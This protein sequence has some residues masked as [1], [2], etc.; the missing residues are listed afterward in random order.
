MRRFFSLSLATIF[1]VSL[2]GPASA[3]IFPDVPESY[4]Y[5][6]AI[7]G[8]VNAGVITGN[9]DG[10]FTPNRAVNRAE[11]LKMLYKASGKTPDTASRGCFRDVE[12]GSWYEP[13]VCDAAA[14][15]FVQG[16]DDGTFRPTVSVNRAE[17]VKMILSVFGL[18]STDTT[19]AAQQVMK[20]VDV[21]PTDWFTTY[22]I[23][24]YAHAILP[25]PGQDSGHLYPGL[26]LLRGEAAAMIWNGM[27]A[28]G[29]VPLMVSLS[30]SLSSISSYSSASLAPHSLGE[31]GS[32]SS[33]F[34]SS[35]PSGPQMTFNISLPYESSTKFV[36]I[37]PM[38]YLFPVGIART[39]S[40]VTTMQ[41]DQPGNMTC[42]LY[43]L[44]SSGFTYEYYLGYQDGPTCTI[45]ASVNPGNYQLQLQTFVANA[46][47]TVKGT[48]T[49]GDGNDGFRE[50][51]TLLR[52]NAKAGFLSSGDYQDFYRFSVNTPTSLQVSVGSD[53]SCRVF[54]TEGVD[55]Q[56]FSAP[57]CN[58][59]YVYQ[60]GDYIIAIS[61]AI[62]ASQQ[63]AYTVVVQ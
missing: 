19:A 13:Y 28:I 57:Q 60:P 26:P 55:M 20:F 42:R 48:Y 37:N 21:T 33:V 23:T 25:I 51:Q 35:K 54:P 41:P 32:V 58:E 63:Q 31:G 12:R 18:P 43:A 50:A 53:A 8:L 5:Q 30:S 2:A 34:S 22:L 44:N 6:K 46:P 52:G 1:V 3:A 36:A 45:L 39:V 27:A 7:E 61:R 62:S 29:G 10:S 11:M 49:T 16:Y 40:I 38:V 24:A 15:R 14:R 4:L 59:T 47:Y 9:P 17:A 56:G